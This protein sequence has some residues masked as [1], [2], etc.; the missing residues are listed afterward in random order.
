ME[1]SCT[2]NRVDLCER[3]CYRHKYRMDHLQHS[4]SDSRLY[5]ETTCYE[6]GISAIAERLLEAIC[7]AFHAECRIPIRDNSYLQFCA[8]ADQYRREDREY[9]QDRH[10]DGNLLTL[11]KASHEGLVI[12]PRGVPH[13]V[14]ILEDEA[15]VFTGS[16]L[17][18][19]SGGRIPFMDHAVRNPPKS[20]SRSSLVYFVLPDLKVPYARLTDRSPVHLEALANQLHQGFGNRPFTDK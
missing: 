17:T 10:E 4:F 13:K 7:V 1:R 9:L 20:V 15:I 5:Q 12:F 2:T 8:Y 16:L 6:S 18:V 19:L 11:V 3:Y 14:D